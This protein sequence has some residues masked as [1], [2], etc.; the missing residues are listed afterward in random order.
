MRSDIKQFAGGPRPLGKKKKPGAVSRSPR[1]HMDG[2]SFISQLT[3]A[4]VSRMSHA[5]IH[6]DIIECAVNCTFKRSFSHEPVPKQNRTNLPTCC[7]SVSLTCA[8]VAMIC[9]ATLAAPSASPAPASRAP[10]RTLPFSSR[11]PCS[12]SFKFCN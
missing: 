12:F 1:Q 9:G 4:K 2:N 5:V 8:L 10:F 6:V 3:G 7:L 11:A